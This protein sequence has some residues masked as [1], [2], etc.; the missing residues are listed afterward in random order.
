MMTPMI[1]L[2]GPHGFIHGWHFVGVPAGGVQEHPGLLKKG[3]KIVTDLGEGEGEH[4]VLANSKVNDHIYNVA[5]R[6][7]AGVITYNQFATPETPKPAPPPPREQGYHSPGIEQRIATAKSGD[8]R[9]ALKQYSGDIATGKIKFGSGPMA[10]SYPGM[11]RSGQTISEHMRRQAA[12]RGPLF[13][14]PAGR[15][16]DLVGPHGYVHGWK[17]VGIPG[18]KNPRLVQPGDRIRTSF[19]PHGLSN[20]HE[21]V[22][23][24]H[25]TNMTMARVRDMDSGAEHTLRM[26]HNTPGKGAMQH[27]PSGGTGKMPT[28][29]A[30]ETSAGRRELLRRGHALPPSRP[31][32]RPGYPIGDADHWDR[33]FEAVGRSGGGARRAALRKL[34]IKTAPEFGKT[35]KIKGSWLDKGAKTMANTRLNQIL[36]ADA[37]GDNSETHAHYHTHAGGSTAHSHPMFGAD[38]PRGSDTNDIG[39]TSQ[40]P[41]ALRTPAGSDYYGK[42]GFSGQQV[43]LSNETVDLAGGRIRQA[44]TSMGDVLV[45]RLP[46][47]RAA[48]RHRRGGETI[49]EVYKTPE[50]QWTSSFGD[51][52]LSPHTHQRAAL[53]E[54]IGTHNKA[55]GTPF[56]GPTTN[57]KP[58]IPQ[59][60]QSPLMQRFGIPA[61]S[62]ALAS[63]MNG[64]SDGPRATG[65]S[66][67]E[68]AGLTPKGVTIYKK[69]KQ[70]M[71]APR[72]LAFA[73]RAQNMGGSEK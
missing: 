37:D 69:L 21:V 54:L 65:S 33:A 70:R 56:H 13:T 43:R 30:S 45:T 10:Q 44:V 58:L 35:G 41:E 27:R 1:D 3:D 7:K 2:V 68:T 62:V 51:K 20:E 39:T 40:T 47:G 28:G 26:P 49:G 48:I 24:R 23:V 16:I 63:P 19:G 42:T 18:V 29:K 59:P 64:S 4:E 8:W 60:T 32:G 34:L 9:Y 73:R 31:G 25:G 36:L 11:A 72:A 22:S 57:G 71:P 61:A 66:A 17:F 52:A 67:S 55:S 6:S 50:G 14:N 53:A 12:K 5:L 38:S 46:N 15:L